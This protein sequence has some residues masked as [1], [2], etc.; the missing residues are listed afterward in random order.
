MFDLQNNYLEE[1]DLWS[2]IL[3]ATYFSVKSM[4]RTMMQAAL[5]QLLFLREMILTTPFISDWGNIRLRKQKKR[6]EQPT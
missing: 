4:Y 3:A 2:G 6:Q 1:D 5:G